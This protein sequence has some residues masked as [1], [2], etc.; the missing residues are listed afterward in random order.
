MTKDIRWTQRFDNYK[1]ALAQLREAVRLYAVANG[2]TPEVSEIIPCLSSI[3]WEGA[4][5]VRGFPYRWAP[6]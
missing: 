4:I 6:G 3:V 5:N 1:R 2:G